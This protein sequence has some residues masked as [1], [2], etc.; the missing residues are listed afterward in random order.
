MAKIDTIVLDLDDTLNSLTMFVL[1]HL[2]C[3]VL[4]YDYDLFPKVGY[5][6]IAAWSELTD[7]PKPSVPDFWERVTEDIWACAPRSSQFWLLEWAAAVV[8]RKNVIIAT[9]PTKSGDCLSGKHTWIERHLPVWAQRQYAATPR[10]HFLAHERALLVDDSD[11][12]VLEFETYKNRGG[13]AILVPRPWNSLRGTDP[14]VY[15]MTQLLKFEYGNV[16]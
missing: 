12:N 13:N 10:K 7:L 1:G 15:L 4:P 5:D 11:S 3:D 9:V 14:D 2:G 16:T 8:G 6:M